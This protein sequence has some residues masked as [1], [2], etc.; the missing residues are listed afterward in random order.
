MTDST[1]NPISGRNST[2]RRFRFFVRSIDSGNIYLPVE[3]KT[4]PLICRLRQGESPLSVFDV[5]SFPEARQ[6]F[7]ALRK[8]FDFPFWAATECSVPD[9]DNPSVLKPLIL[10][11]C[12]KYMMDAMLSRIYS[13]PNG[14]VLIT[15]SVPKCGLTSCIQAYIRWRQ[16][17][18]E[19]LSSITYASSDSDL[20]TL[21]QNFM[22]SIPCDSNINTFTHMG[23]DDPADAFFSVF[24][25]CSFAENRSFSFIHMA[26]MSR[27]PDK[28]ALKTSLT[29]YT[30][31]RRLK[32]QSGNLVV[33]EGDIPHHQHFNIDSFKD[34]S[35]PE[36]IRLIRL[37]PFSD[38]P[39]FLLKYIQF[40]DPSSS[41]LYI[42]LDQTSG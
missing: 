23:K 31:L 3:M 42:D 22:R 18:V 16:L 32:G 35:V 25:D 19:P 38:N 34:D 39:F 20:S 8:K 41:S 17:Y 9:I 26:D 40:S 1:F 2:G 30:A 24:S 4:H 28:G 6:A 29:Y 27:W 13:G 12:Q 10:N 14:L 7:C 15:K 36:Q 5:S 37:D 33:L 21:R 11:H